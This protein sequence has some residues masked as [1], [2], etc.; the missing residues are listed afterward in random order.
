LR[1]DYYSRLVLTAGYCRLR[2][3]RVASA[4]GAAILGLRLAGCAVPTSAPPIVAT[5]SQAVTPVA[6]LPEVTP[7]LPSTASPLSTSGPSA[8]L[9]SCSPS[10]AAQHRP[11]PATVT[12]WRTGNYLTGQ[13]VDV[14]NQVRL[15]DGTLFLALGGQRS[16]FRL[17][18]FTPDGTLSQVLPD[19]GSSVLVVDGMVETGPAELAVL[20]QTQDGAE[21]LWTVDAAG[22]VLGRTPQPLLDGGTV[23]GLIRC[24]AGLVA[25]GQSPGGAAVW[26]TAAASA[27]FTPVGLP[28]GLTTVDTAAAGAGVLVISG[29]RGQHGYTARL[30]ADQPDVVTRLDHLL[31]A[32]NGGQLAYLGQAGWALLA[33][34]GLRSSTVLLSRDGASWREAPA[35]PGTGQVDGSTLHAANGELLVSGTDDSGPRSWTGAGADW[36]VSPPCRGPSPHGGTALDALLDGAGDQILYSSAGTGLTICI[37]K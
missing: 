36:T 1:R 22:R 27:L 15:A 19:D 13:L 12:G 18:R 26:A 35:L 2:G 3:L 34:P 10:P 17:V 24:G 6:S 31:G 20:G 28:A 14:A 11:G 32:V 5:G 7:G 25:F 33:H 23:E 37:S 8:G 9:R 21:S 16:H 4:F 30:S 29:F